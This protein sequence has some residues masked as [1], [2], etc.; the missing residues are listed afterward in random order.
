[1]QRSERTWCG[2]YRERCRSRGRPRPGAGNRSRI[3]TG[4]PCHGRRSALLP[5]H[6]VVH[7]APAVPWG[8]SL[9]SAPAPLLEGEGRRARPR[10]STLAYQVTEVQSPRHVS[11]ER[12]NGPAPTLASPCNQGGSTGCPTSTFVSAYRDRP[13]AASEPRWV[14]TIRPPRLRPGGDTIAIG[15]QLDAWRIFGNAASE[16]QDTHDRSGARRSVGR[17]MAVRSQGLPPVPTSPAAT[18][19]SDEVCRALDRR[20]SRQAA[21]FI[22]RIKAGKERRESGVY[23]WQESFARILARLGAASRASPR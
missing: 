23:P 6:R 20:S 12:K 9:P 3:E 1:M 15:N 7:F 2:I 4:R 11:Q 22:G 21:P 18:P 16:R 8:S 5:A 14:P 19:R 13:V 17:R 10:I